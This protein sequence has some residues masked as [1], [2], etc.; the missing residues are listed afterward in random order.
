MSSLN[1]TVEHRQPED[2]QFGSVGDNGTWTG[3]VR[4]LIDK[5]AD[6][7]TAGLSLNFARTEALDFLQPIF[8][9]AY[10]IT[11]IRSRGRGVW[12]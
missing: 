7:S 3:I 11:H 10:T 9:L 12:F 1:F 4:K 6:I 5:E 2:G 8:R